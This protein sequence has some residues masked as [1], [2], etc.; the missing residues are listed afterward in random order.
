MTN[1]VGVLM[2]GGL[3]TRLWPWSLKERPK[4]FLP[5]LG[6]KSLV[7]MTW[8]RV[9]PLFPPER[10]LL[11]TNEHLIDLACAEVPEIPRA[12]VIGEPKSCNTAPC[13]A[14]AAALCERDWGRDS[15]MVVLS[16]D[17]Y[18][19][20]AAGFRSALQTAVSAAEKGGCLVTLGIAPTRPETGY[21]YLECDRMFTEIADDEA[22]PLF[23]FREKPNL[24]T[25]V[26]Y[27]EGR[28]HLWNM[29]NFIWRCDAIL[30]ELETHLPELL[31]RAREVLPPDFPPS[32]VILEDYYCNLPPRLCDSIDFGLMEK[33]KTIR[34]VPCRV[35]WDDVGSWPV[36]RRLR[37]DE[38]DE[39]GNLSLVRHL[40]IET[41]DTLVAGT[42]S[43]DGIVVTVGVDGLVVV[44][45]R[46][47]VLVVP[48]DRVD[49]MRL[50]VPA[51][52]EKG[53][54]HLL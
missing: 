19:G 40:G 51:M 31:A 32:P 42:E 6:E 39:R 28:R 1:V 18:V 22:T 13:V 49:L 10:A 11:F 17:H 48:A 43:D 54:D 5:L 34:V 8:D 2:A 25:A 15:V 45:D 35:P 46:E 50:V 3:G 36:L 21:G 4:Q 53:W 30:D 26:R 47:R 38:L 52:R 44:R 20:D 12:N 41:T 16:A 23:R 14:L 9:A 37:E 24:E 29:G 33:A 27:L 7:R